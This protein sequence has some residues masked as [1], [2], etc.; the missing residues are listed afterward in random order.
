M[1]D[2]DTPATQTAQ[3]DSAAL[4]SLFG[5]MRQGAT[6]AG[7]DGRATPTT[8][9]TRAATKA[10]KKAKPSPQAV[11][12]TPYDGWAF[13]QVRED[14]PQ[15]SR[16]LERRTKGYDPRKLPGAE[17]TALVA[18]AKAQGGN[19]DWKAIPGYAKT[20]ALASDVFAALRQYAPTLS[21]PAQMDAAYRN[22]HT[23]MESM[24][25]TS[26]YQSLHANTQGDDW[27]S[28]VAT[29]AMVPE[30]L[31]KLRDEQQNQER[32][33][34]QQ[35][36]GGT[37]GQDGQGSADGQQ[38]GQQEIA[39]AMRVAARGAA[40]HAQQAVDDARALVEA[41]GG[42]D[43]S[44]GPGWGHGEG[45]GDPLGGL[46]QKAEFAQQLMNDEMLRRIA[47]LAG[48]IRLIASQVQREKVQRGV[49]EVVGVEPTS[50]VS[51]L[52]PQETSLLAQPELVPLFLARWVE[53][54][55]MG[56][57]FQ[58]RK[59]EGRG[60]IVAIVDESGSMSG[61]R[62]CWAKAVVLALL[63]IA[64]KQKRD[65]RVIHAGASAREMLVEDYP[66]GKA[67]PGQVIATARKFFG[68][69]TSFDAPLTAALDAINTSV[70]RRAD[71]IHITDGECA[72]SAEVLN[73][74]DTSRRAK[75]WRAVGILIG[76]YGGGQVLA[77]Y[78]DEVVQMNMDARADAA[79]FARSDRKALL[80]TF[81]I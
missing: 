74:L 5:Q 59:P 15:L 29:A 76:T 48:R 53:G 52:L 8:A 31:D 46:R 25:Q 60:P 10:A 40:D 79:D 21:D 24:L 23:I 77:Q 62:I 30:L 65:L 3:E 19:V 26:E 38:Q 75:G 12:A 80:A 50:D 64:S 42:Q 11:Q 58:G 32:Q 70:Y 18:Q 33:R 22:H 56:Y 7:R 57:R 44:L 78:C 37:A 51:R 16:M 43:S 81:N 67:Q 28:G 47:R 41:F 20:G 45:Q 55:T 34:Q 61:D 66:Q 4:D 69:G 49:D 68:G 6:D 36:Q 54:Q 17:Q 72:V 63:A 1:S 35:E 71:I 9:A 73:A 39:Q 2:Q 13:R 14:V 27:A